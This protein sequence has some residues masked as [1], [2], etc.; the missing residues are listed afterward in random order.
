M[1]KE[2][3]N[4]ESITDRQMYEKAT[5]YMNELIEYA[6][7]KGYLSHPENDNEYTREI[8]RI[9]VMCADYENSFMKF[10]HL[11]VKTP[12]ILSIET[13][14]KKRHSTNGKPPNFWK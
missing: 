14:M 9:G 3:K 10:K 4:I 2:F 6:T 12:L 8:G 1:K 13:Q 11:K 7:K 5:A